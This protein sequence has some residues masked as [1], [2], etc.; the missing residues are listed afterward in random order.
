MRDELCRG[1]CALRY[2]CVEVPV[3]RG[4]CVSR[5]L[6]VEVPV[7][8][9]TC[10]SRYLCVEARVCRGTCVSGRRVHR[11]KRRRPRAERRDLATRAV[12]TAPA[13]R[14]LGLH[15]LVDLRRALVDDRRA[16]VA[17]VA[18]DAV[19]ARV[20]I[21]AED[22]DRQ[23]RG[24]ERRLRRVP[25]GERRLTRVA[26]ALVLHPRGLHDEK[27]RRLVAEDHLRDHVLHELV[28]A[29]LLAERLALAGVLD[30]AL[31]AGSDPAAPPPGDQEAA[32]VE[33]VHRDL[34]SFAFL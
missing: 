3:C 4:T 29:D 15:H 8:R 5:Y 13:E 21:R 28:A 17:E 30:G 1:T 27:L 9:G 24:L 32:L 26:L 23:V 31:E 18:L 34:E 14:I 16:R 2:L 11:R 6:C 25:L 33:G 12:Q 19:L 20:A 7:C 10:A 22:L